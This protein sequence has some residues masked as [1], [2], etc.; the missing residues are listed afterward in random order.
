MA[1]NIEIVL[2]PS[3]YQFHSQGGNVVLIDVARFTSTMITA[4]AN[5]AVSA[6][7]YPD[8][9]IP[10]RLKREHGYLLVGETKGLDIEGFDFNNS[11]VAMTPENVSGRKLAF[12]TSNGT[13]TRS[14][15][16]NYDAIYAGGFINA[17]ALV[18]RLIAE[19]RNVKLVCSGRSRNIAIED[20]I[21][22][23]YVAE[24]LSADGGFTYNDDSV[25]AS[26]LMWQMARENP[27]DFVL[28]MSPS[29]NYSY[30]K[31]PHYR[32]DIDTVFLM[33]TYDVVPEEIAP[34]KFVVKR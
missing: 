2:A 16:D 20:M 5:G 7:V 27:L 23:G 28:R 9:E 1:T 6:E 29:V 19:N 33:D 12:S 4:L 15:I 31:R 17:K 10:L 18:D 26:M 13:Y 24:R 3:L 22:A 25:P 30:G 21:F 34:L 11:P 8:T 32:A 14:V